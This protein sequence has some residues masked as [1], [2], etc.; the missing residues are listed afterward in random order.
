MRFTTK[1]TTLFTVI[2]LFVG[3]ILS[4]FVYTSNIK[5]LEKQITDRLED[6]AF[7]T[8]D[9][10]DR[11]LFENYANM[12]MLTTDPV[13][14]SKK[15][16]P[17]HITKRLI[18][19]ENIYKIYSYLSLFDLNRIRIADTSGTN[20]GK[21]HPFTEYWIGITEGKEFVMDIFMS[22]VFKKAVFYFA[23]VIKDEN[24]EP[25]R[26]VVSRIPTE[27]LYEI[28]SQAA[29][30]HAAEKKYKLTLINKDGLILYSNYNP[31]GILKDR[32]PDLD[33]VQKFLQSGKNISSERHLFLGEEEITTF[34]REQ[35]YMDF[36]GNDWALIMCIPTKVAFEP[37]IQL[38]NRVMIILAVIG[39]F[40][41]LVIYLFSRTISNPIKKLRDTAIEIG[42][43]NLNAK[44]NILSKDEIGQLAESFNNMATNLKKYISQNEL[45]LNSAG[46]G[47]LGLDLN[48]NHTFV[49]PAASRMLGYEVEELIG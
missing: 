1:L 26:V 4:Y 19:F 16:T 7:H 17:E 30:I 43:G 41:F 23:F 24:G 49:N 39:V 38:R 20:I 32:S 44:V 35:G 34:A 25:F 48:G 47:I 14:R 6:Q 15:S 45:I 28:T 46:E 5:I 2:G 31:E 10:I 21:Q 22:G 37:A 27:Q 3:I 42:R 8:I 13:L 9:K 11:M 33:V 18:E 36:K 29:G 40:A 12:K